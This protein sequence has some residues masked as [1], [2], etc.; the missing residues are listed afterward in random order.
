[1]EHKASGFRHAGESLPIRSGTQALQNVDLVSVRADQ[2]ARLA[3]LHATK[4]AR[5]CFLGRS[6]EKLL[7]TGHFLFESPFLEHR[8]RRARGVQSAFES[9][10][11]ARTIRTRRCPRVHA[12]GIP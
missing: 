6:P 4:N 1:M 11:G 8:R 7:K 2:N 10:R 5:R 9:R 12:A 3:S